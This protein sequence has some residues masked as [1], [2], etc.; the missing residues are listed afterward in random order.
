ME[1]AVEV[2]RMTEADA[3]K[4]F[5]NFVHSRGYGFNEAA[6]PKDRMLGVE[7]A[8]GRHWMCLHHLCD[9]ATAWKEFAAR[10]A[11]KEYYLTHR[12]LKPV[13]T[14]KAGQPLS[15]PHWV[16]MHDVLTEELFPQLSVDEFTGCC[17]LA[18][19]I[20]YVKKSIW[21]DDVMVEDFEKQNKG[22][23]PRKELQRKIRI[24]WTQND[25]KKRPAENDGRKKAFRALID[26]YL[27]LATERSVL[28]RRERG[29]MTHEEFDARLKA[30]FTQKTEEMNGSA[31]AHPEGTR[32]E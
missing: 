2:L 28:E 18:D 1:Y 6:L 9:P 19:G 10:M 13:K 8:E 24:V 17:K 23:S 11:V 31:C 27:P 16:A 29:E 26:K 3:A 32:T 20:E 4:A 14:Q 30:K 21:I 7:L 12:N 5:E 25:S 22:V 15:G